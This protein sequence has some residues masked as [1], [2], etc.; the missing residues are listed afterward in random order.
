MTKLSNWLVKKTNR[1][2]RHFIRHL[3]AVSAAILKDHGAI[4]SRRERK[5]RAKAAGTTFVRYTNN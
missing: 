2:R 4:L 1:S 5:A 3:S